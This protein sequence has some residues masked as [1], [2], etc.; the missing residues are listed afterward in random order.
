LKIL[1]I[2]ETLNLYKKGF[3]PMAVNRENEEVKF[4]KPNKR[5]IIPINNFHL[6]KKLFKEFQKKKYNYKIDCKFEKV[7]EFCSLPRK[8]EGGS[9]INK[10]IKNTYNELN[11]LGLAHSIECWEKN[12]LLGGLYGV[13]IN[14]CFFGESMFHKKTNTSKLTLLYLITI[15]IKNKF[16]LLDS[17]FYNEHLIQFGGY[18]ITDNKYQ[19]IL[20]HGLQEKNYFRDIPKFQESIE[21]LQS[22]IHKS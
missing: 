5:F 12:K 20:K 3:F 14:S 18:E 19:K 16:S 11:R 2:K 22:L 4:Y 9:W 13:S 6:P 21:I 8:K 10:V 1:N 15:L 17:Q 7:I